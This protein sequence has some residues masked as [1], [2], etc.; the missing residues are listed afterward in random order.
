MP[1]PNS[2]NEWLATTSIAVLASTCHCTVKGD[3]LG[4]LSVGPVEMFPHRGGR[5]DMPCV[6]HVLI[7]VLALDANAG[8]EGCAQVVVDVIK[9]DEVLIT[10]VARL[11]GLL[12]L[13]HL[14]EYFGDA[15]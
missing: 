9:V 8:F 11:E 12:K 15:A 2:K 1:R 5:D 4:G 7:R 3:E 13:V 10:K 6:H 14:V